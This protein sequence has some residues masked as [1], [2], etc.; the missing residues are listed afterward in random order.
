MTSESV[1]YPEFNESGEK[2]P[3]RVPL[4]EDSEQWEIDVVHA[5]ADYDP[6]DPDTLANEPNN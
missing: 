1:A 5:T 3:V 6:F 2:N 4:T